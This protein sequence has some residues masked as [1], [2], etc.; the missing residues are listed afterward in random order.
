MNFIT[1]SYWQFARNNSTLLLQQYQYKHTPLCLITL[2][3]GQNEVQGKVGAYLTGQLLQWFR[4]LSF[5]HIARDPDKS[6]STL[7]AQLENFLA[8]L[9]NELISCGLLSSIQS[10]PLSGILCFDIM[11]LI[12]GKRNQPIYL[13]NKGFG[14]SCIQNLYNELISKSEISDSLVLRQGI[15]QQDVGILFATE[16]LCR[17]LTEQEIQECM[18]VEEIR[19]EDQANRHLQELGSKA[20]ALGGRNMAAAFLLTRS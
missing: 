8:R 4:S 17:Q 1:A 3:E 19:T 14:Q 2:C 7:E 16:T 18:Y 9:R 12:F 10:L 5:S 13:L 15:L 6:L 20:E 11:F